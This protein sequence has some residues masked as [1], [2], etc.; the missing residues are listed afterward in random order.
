VIPVLQFLGEV[1]VQATHLELQDT[2]RR[3]RHQHEVHQQQQQAALVPPKPVWKT[4]GTSNSLISPTMRPPGDVSHPGYHIGESP[5]PGGV[6][7]PT[8]VV[9]PRV[10]FV[11]EALGSLC[12][13]FVKQL[14][15]LASYPSFDKLWFRFLHVFGYFLGAAHSFEPILLNAHPDDQGN[16]RQ[17]ELLAAVELARDR[18]QNLIDVLVRTKIFKRRPELWI[19]TVDIVSQFRFCPGLA[20]SNIASASAVSSP[21]SKASR[22][23]TDASDSPVPA[24]ANEIVDVNGNSLDTQGD[25]STAVGSP[26]QNTADEPIVS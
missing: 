17:Q 10:A 21:M 7:A 9:M 25:T 23:P 20:D 11:D 12:T 26:L 14:P 16:Y 13:T 3:L 19:V 15:R 1:L 4:T 22:T 24:A 6:V 2:P 18:A 8:A 5:E